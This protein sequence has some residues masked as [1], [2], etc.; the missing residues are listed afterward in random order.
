MSRASPCGHY[1]KVGAEGHQQ[2]HQAQGAGEQGHGPAGLHGPALGCGVPR[3]GEAAT[4]AAGPQKAGRRRLWTAPGSLELDKQKAVTVMAPGGAGF[5]QFWQQLFTYPPSW[6]ADSPC[7]A[8]GFPATGS[9]WGGLGVSKHPWFRCG[10]EH[11]SFAGSFYTSCAGCPPQQG[12]LEG[13]GVRTRGWGTQ[14]EGSWSGS[15]M[16]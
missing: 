12:F 1:P 4:L 9:G 13:A 11:A 8:S 10:L 16:S 3:G 7:P 6:F 2:A 5:T 15:P 14:A